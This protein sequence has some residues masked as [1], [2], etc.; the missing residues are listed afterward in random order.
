MEALVLV[1]TFCPSTFGFPLSALSDVP[2]MPV[3]P[4]GST[5]PAHSFASRLV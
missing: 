1:S 2:F 5:Q 4:A 3:T